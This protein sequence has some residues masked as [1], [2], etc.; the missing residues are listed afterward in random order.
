MHP[1]HAPQ[2]A[3]LNP[4]TVYGETKVEGEDLAMESWEK[5]GVDVRGIRYPASFPTKP[6]QVGGPRIMPLKF[7]MLLL[8]LGI[9]IALFEKTLA[10]Q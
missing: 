1:K 8:M 5:F 3:A 4:T 9:T 2:D 6:Q 10:F 7:S